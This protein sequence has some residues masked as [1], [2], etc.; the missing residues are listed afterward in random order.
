MMANALKDAILTVS[1]LPQSA[2]E[3]CAWICNSADPEPP[4]IVAFASLVGQLKL[5]QPDETEGAVEYT[6]AQAPEMS[7]L[8]NSHQSKR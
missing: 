5:A 1:E 2:E 8:D 3:L 6:L 7:G 4:T